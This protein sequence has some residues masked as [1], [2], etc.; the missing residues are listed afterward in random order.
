M[1]LPQF[2]GLSAPASVE[3]LICMIISFISAF[4]LCTAFGMLI[5]TVRLNI[6]WGD[7]PTY[8][9]MLIGGVLSGGYLPLQL[10]PKALQHFL[11]VQPFA[12]YL[13]I[14]LRFYIGTMPYRDAIWA[15]GLQILW[16]MVFILSGKMLMAK[17]L[18][19][20]IIQGG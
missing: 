4:L 5:C 17:R 2:Y 12:G 15:I 8:F 13:D 1:L 7:G 16:S 20:I 3:G 6:D 18:R 19:S 10:W 14:P 9:L 11:L